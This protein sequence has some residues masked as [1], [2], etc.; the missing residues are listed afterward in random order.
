MEGAS[1]GS[2]ESE[3]KKL[4]GNGVE[5]STFIRIMLSFLEFDPAKRPRAVEALLDPAFE[6]V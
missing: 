2:I 5:V 1:L 6:E 3:L 4:H